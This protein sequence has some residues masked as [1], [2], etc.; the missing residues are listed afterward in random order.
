MIRTPHTTISHALYA[1]RTT[2][3]RWTYTYRPTHT[4]LSPPSRSRD[5]A[6]MASVPCRSTGATVAA[7]HIAQV[8]HTL[9]GMPS[10]SIY[11]PRDSSDEGTQSHNQLVTP[12][13]TDQGSGDP[14]GH[15]RAQRPPAPRPAPRRARH[16]RLASSFDKAGPG[17]PY[18][19][20]P[21]RERADCTQHGT[22]L[23]IVLRCLV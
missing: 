1:H 15:H 17:Y 2:T 14:R 3:A 6:C 8:T 20:P 21:R 23:R 9:H 10:Q 13:D 11:T 22:V 5:H 16:D 19:R 4:P 7:A 12:T 18:C